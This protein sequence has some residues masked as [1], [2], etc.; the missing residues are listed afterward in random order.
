LVV[1][2]AWLAGCGE[3]VRED[4]TITWSA[5]GDAV[6]FQHG[7]EGVFVAD[8]EGAELLKVFQPGM[9]V[10]ATSTPL[11][12]PDGKRL[13]FTTGRAA[14]EN[15]VAP[16]QLDWAASPEGRQYARI[17]VI[18]TCYL[19]EAAA[20]QNAEPPPPQPIFEARCDHVG[21]VAANLAVRWHADA[22][23][24]LYVG[25]MENGRHALFEIDLQTKTSRRAFQH[26]ADALVFDF[27]P[28]GSYLCVGICTGGG[29][30]RARDGLWIGRADGDKEAD[31]WWH[32]PSSRMD[33]GTESHALLERL[34]ASRPA[35][36]ADESQFAF[37]CCAV[38][39]E[40]KPA[41]TY[42]LSV[43][44][45]VG[46]TMTP[47]AD[48]RE[49][50]RDLHWSPDGRTLGVV[51]G[52]R[53]EGLL[54]LLVRGEELSEPI[55]E[56]PVRRFA[57]WDSSGER[58][59]YI[60]PDPS[61]VPATEMGDTWAFLILSDPLSRDAVHLAD[62]DGRSARE[63][64]SGTRVTFPRWSP[65]EAKLSLWFTFQPTYRSWLSRVLGFG[66][67]PGDPAAI[68]DA[69]SGEIGWMAVSPQEKV[70]IGHYYLLK[71]DYERAW[72]WY[73]EAAAELPAPERPTVEEFM[74]H[75]VPANN[76]AV[77]QFYCLEKLG[78]H[79]DA[80]QKLSLFAETYL[81]R[82]NEPAARDQPERRLHAADE[83][84]LKAVL[85]PESFS[86]SL[87]CD[88]YVAEV[89][90]SL[91]AAADAEQLFA[92]RQAEAESDAARLSAAIVLAQV[93]LLEGQRAE[94]A[95]V[96][97]DSVG[98][99]LLAAWQ[100]KPVERFLDNILVEPDPQVFLFVAGGMSL[101]PMCDG[102]FLATLPAER[103]A[104]IAARWEAL[105]SDAR[106]DV[107]RLA[108]DLHLQA[109]YGC[110]DQTDKQEQVTSRLEANPQRAGLPSEDAVRP[111]IELLR[112]ARGAPQ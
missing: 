76:F 25:Q 51:Q 60:S 30:D 24:V 67:R 26:D 86:A 108:I 93:L 64:F 31:S 33:A 13:I 103:L 107:S 16:S 95:Q 111:I 2:S 17:P 6:G 69:K 79:D 35:W 59:A 42:W 63:I 28:N 83:R 36:T 89:L 29:G 66:L 47:I 100:P 41:V 37:V 14:G 105:R 88:L 104:A 45:P 81:P 58:L 73:E 62:G 21:Y 102:E 77:F 55:N 91:D 32:V 98:P 56:H 82:P 9:D 48:S 65:S 1:A 78:R 112:V 72:K 49:P 99:L 12:S 43:A 85:A 34:R 84:W 96:M 8:N 7:E 50:F 109:A 27:S 10:L 70:Q 74:R 3:P 87:L 46:K 4:R 15:V 75:Y 38:E 40:P 23:R 20:D 92:K 71:K 44:D 11:W 68:F 90:L 101:L 18:Y 97:T 61:L 57:G 52:G 106:D 54:R 53:D 5:Q 19:R 22:N 39:I 110:L 94:Y 80:R